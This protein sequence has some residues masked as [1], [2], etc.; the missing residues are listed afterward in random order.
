MGTCACVDAWEVYRKS[1]MHQVCVLAQTNER[2]EGTVSGWHER[3]G[4]RKDVR[5]LYTLHLARKRIRTR[6][7]ES[8]RNRNRKGKRPS[9]V[10]S[11]PSTG[12]GIG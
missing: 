11:D 12:T 3:K 9:E 1:S 4:S 5:L 6:H 10:G 8:I 7:S 2:R